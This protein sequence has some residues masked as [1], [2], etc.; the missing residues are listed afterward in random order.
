VRSGAGF[1]RVDF[2]SVAVRDG[3]VVAV[4]EAAEGSVLGDTTVIDVEGA[5]V[6]PGF[7]DCH[8][9]LGWAGEAFWHVNWADEVTN[10]DTA[11]ERV[12]LAAMR[13]KSGF[14]L[15]GGNWS[16]EALPDEE[17]PT[18]GELDAT[19]PC[20][21]MFL[22][23]DD[24]AVGMQADLTVVSHDIVTDGRVDIA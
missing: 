7:V 1:A 2:G 20:T 22:R 14:W 13:I 21:P 19:V 5:L 11:L 10:H 6:L 9:H 12:R 15:L 4:G 23:S 8:T 3:V 16:R 18:P 17:L 24:A